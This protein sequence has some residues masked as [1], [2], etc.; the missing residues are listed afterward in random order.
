MEGLEQ[1]ATLDKEMSV[2][3]TISELVKT[4]TEEKKHFDDVLKNA[5]TVLKNLQRDVKKMKP[6]KR[7]TVVD[8]E[9]KR[10]SG[11]DKPVLV[12]QELR[13]LLGLEDK[14]YPRSDVNSRVTAYIKEHTLQNPENKREMLLD[15]TEAGLRLKSVLK[16]DQPLTFFNIQ[17]YLKVHLIKPP[18]DT[19]LEMK[20]LEYA[21]KMVDDLSELMHT[22]PQ[23]LVKDE[24]EV[25][26]TPPKPVEVDDSQ[27]TKKV[28]KKKVSKTR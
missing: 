7:Q 24:E 26:D 6:K 9:H 16:P 3:D 25:D 5:L 2:N 20:N 14:E 19:S 17:R 8:P 4:L 28:M 27:Q 1:T 12:S 15:T 18:E 23:T 21:N 13:D 22:I 11:L 10:T